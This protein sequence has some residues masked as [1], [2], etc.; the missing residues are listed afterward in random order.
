VYGTLAD[1]RRLAAKHDCCVFPSK[2][3]LRVRHRS[4]ATGK[5]RTLRDGLSPSACIEF[6]EKRPERPPSKFIASIERRYARD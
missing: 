6:I 4:L 5:W 1:L 3:G 2:T